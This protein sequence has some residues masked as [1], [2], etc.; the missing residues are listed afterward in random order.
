MADVA[1]PPGLVRFGVF[2]VDLRTGELRKSGLK[3]KLTGQAFQVLAM[4]LER[5]GDV[6]TR[7]ELQ[8]QL[9]PDG[10]FVDFDHNLNAAINKIREVLGDLAESPRFVETLPRR[11]YRFITPVD[12]AA[13]A[14]TPG[15]ARGEIRGLAL[16]ARRRWPT[17]AVAVLGY[18]V[19]TVGAI[20]VYQRLRQP[21]PPMQRVLTRL[22]FDAG[23]QFGATWSPDGR[24]IAYSSDKGGKFDIWVHPASGGNAVQITKGP[25]HNWQ[26]DWSP[27]GKQIVFRSERGDGGLYVVPVLG[28]NETRIASYGYSPRWSPNGSQV[29]FRTGLAVA[30]NLAAQF[31]IVSLDGSPPHE[32]LVDFKT[33]H[34][35]FA[36]SAVW[37]PDGRRITVWMQGVEAGP[38]FWT[39]PVAGGFAVK[40]ELAAG[41]VK[42]LGEAALA[43]MAGSG[44]DLRFSW[45]PSGRAIYFERTFGGARNLWELTIDPETL[46]ATAV[47]RLTTDPGT[48]TDFA[49]SP[50]GEKLAFTSRTQHRRIWLF[51]FDAAHRRVAGAGQALT[52]PGLEAFGQNLSRD[53][54]KM[55]FVTLRGGRAELWEKSLMN[56]SETIVAY[57]PTF[58]VWSPDG[59]R[60]AYSRD[61]E[62]L[63]QHQLFVWS[64]ESRNEEALTASTAPRWLPYDWSGDGKSLLVTQEVDDTR[65]VPG[66]WLLPLDAA[67]FAE[68]K[69]RKVTS[70][71]GYS[72]WQGHFSPDDRWIVFEAVR[73]Q[74]T[75][76]ESTVYVMRASGGEW[77][78]ITDGK[79]WADKPRWSP[80][81]KTIYYVSGR[82]GFFNVWGIRFDPAK[83]HP[84]GKPF[85]VTNLSSPGLMIPEEIS[86]VELSL[87]QDRLTLTMAE[88]SGSIWLL[89]HVN[90]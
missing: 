67:P 58:P 21:N 74:P 23:L 81:G 7:E 86:P 12:S 68:T 18:G 31:H 50:G 1:H 16:H 60:L 88:I 24:F 46:R 20:L 10:T 55:A 35:S 9:W 72:L 70:A 5:P 33:F 13:L 27:D 56:G 4:L 45:A 90:P 32:V 36:K 69:A 62:H 28:G 41:V 87:T 30:A 61:K 42:Q 85:R 89:E 40:S 84:V 39:V 19:L 44:F 6:V 2:E 79:D 59:S 66:I 52:P 54:K 75:G 25:G 47:E 76:P 71:P 22:T 51:P 65:W 8:K 53:G 82:A 78:P 15:T 26:P 17:F 73:Y 38:N 3:L 48:D 11:G 63:Q 77:V 80:D 34:D 49:L 43:G 64:A 57:G 14:S 29:L 37:H 83:G